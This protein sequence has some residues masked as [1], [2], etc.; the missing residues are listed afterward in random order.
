MQSDVVAAVEDV[1][2]YA[3]FSHSEITRKQYA[4]KVNNV[5]V[6]VQR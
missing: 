5:N 6:T 4:K 1:N 2:V 3:E